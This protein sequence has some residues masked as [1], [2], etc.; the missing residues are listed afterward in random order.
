MPMCPKCERLVKGE[1]ERETL[2]LHRTCLLA[3]V[4]EREANAIS[5]YMH[6]IRGRLNDQ[7]RARKKDESS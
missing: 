6:V 7:A 4:H 1:W 5:G 2:V 3:F